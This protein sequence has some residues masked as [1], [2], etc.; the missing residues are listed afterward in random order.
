MPDLASRWEITRLRREHDRGHF[1]C[2]EPA[3]AEFLRRFARQNDEKG[4]SRTFVATRPSSVVVVGYYCVRS[5]AVSFDALT[6]EERRRL[7]RYPVPVVHLARLAVDR[8]E[9]GRG[10]GE[11]LLMHCFERTLRVSEEIGVRAIEVQ[12]K[13]QAARG[14]YG[15]YGFKS[16]L[17]DV[18]HMYLSID[19]IRTAFAPE[20]RRAREPK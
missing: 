2:G 3:L 19:V 8:T 14:F 13:D 7:P 11:S 20:P 17:D 15:R 5:G 12:A 1:D 18:Q 6:D 4:I 10:L 16:L 9:R